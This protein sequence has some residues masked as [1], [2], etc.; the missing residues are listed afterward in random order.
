MKQECMEET[1][2][3]EDMNEESDAQIAAKIG[4][5]INEY[6]EIADRIVRII[7]L[8]KEKRMKQAVLEMKVIDDLYEPGA[9]QEQDDLRVAMLKTQ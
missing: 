8:S 2:E 1:D 9:L 4:L 5:D 3:D 6:T 7:R